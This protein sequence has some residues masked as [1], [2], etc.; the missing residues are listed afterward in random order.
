MRPRHRPIRAVASSLSSAR[1]A[2][3]VAAAALALLALASCAEPSA[4]D[5][6]VHADADG[7]SFIVPSHWSYYGDDTRSLKGTVFTIEILSL[8]DGDPKFLAALPQSIVPQLIARTQYFFDVVEP[9]ND[10]PATV[11][12]LPALH[13]VFPVHVRK[14]DAQSRLDYWIVRSDDRLFA[15]RATYPPEAIPEDMAGV[16]SIIASWKFTPAAGDNAGKAPGNES[17]T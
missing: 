5:R 6:T 9:H 16:D 12:G 1:A 7:Y 17:A 3:A 13:V 4:E 2:L 11:G 15:L 10:E 14:S 8:A